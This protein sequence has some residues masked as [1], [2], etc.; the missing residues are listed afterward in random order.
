MRGLSGA[1]EEKFIDSMRKGKAASP[2]QTAKPF[3]Q[4]ELLLR[5]AKPMVYRF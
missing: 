3:R 2:Q 5:G 4:A 1:A